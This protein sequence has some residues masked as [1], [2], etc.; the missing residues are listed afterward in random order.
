VREVSARCHGVGIFG[1]RFRTEKI[2]LQLSS[3]LISAS[4]RRQ[5][6]TAQR[7]IKHLSWRR[8]ARAL[9]YHRFDDAFMSRSRCPPYNL[10]T[11]LSVDTSG[12]CKSF[13]MDGTRRLLC[14][15][16]LVAILGMPTA[17]TTREDAHRS[18]L[19]RGSRRYKRRSSTIQS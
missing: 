13:S 2:A 9:P 14:L 12:R 8:S 16:R 1:P 7:Q 18:L 3:C 15:D 19:D 6:L 11:N 5:Y 10:R 4:C 17:T